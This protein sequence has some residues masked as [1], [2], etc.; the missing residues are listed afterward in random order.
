MVQPC[1]YSCPKHFATLSSGNTFCRCCGMCIS[2]WSYLYMTNEPLLLIFLC[3]QELLPC[4]G[5][6][7]ILGSHKCSVYP[8]ISCPEGEKFLG[9][10]K[11]QT[12]RTCPKTRPHSSSH[13]W[14]LPLSPPYSCLN[15]AVH[16][17]SC[18]KLIF[19]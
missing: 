1:K 13:V 6:G 18:G 10:A 14:A 7:W 15:S 3:E 11:Y 12:P 2:L 19:K 9:T 17:E 5:T 16:T 8:A 4:T